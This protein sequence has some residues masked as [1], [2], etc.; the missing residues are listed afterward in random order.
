MN[1]HQNIKQSIRRSVEASVPDVLPA[2]LA[3][4]RLKE[5]NIM[6]EE[7]IIQHK[8]IIRWPKRLIPVAAALL[9][10]VGAWIG[11]LN[12]VVDSVVGFDVNPSLQLSVNRQEKVLKV[13][14]RNDEALTVLDD[15]DLKGVSLDVAVNA[16]I[17]SMV[18][19]GYLSE[20]RNSILVTVEHQN[21]EKGVQLQQRLSD[22]IAALLEGFSV[23]GSVMSQTATKDKERERSA[24]QYGISSGKTIL[25]RALIALDP[26]IQFSD[27]AH[28][29]I[30]DLNLLISAR[31]AAV[32]GLEVKGQASS[33]AYIGQEKARSIALMH[34]GVREAEITKIEIELDFEDGK[35]VYEVE[36]QAG[37]M[38]FDYDIDAKDGSV[39]AYESKRKNQQPDDPITAELIGVSRAEDIALTDAG[40]TKREITKLE[41]ELEHEKGRLIYDIEFVYA[42][43]QYEYDI[44]ALTGKILEIEKKKIR[45]NEQPTPTP[46]TTQV[47]KTVTTTMAKGD[48]GAKKAEDI[49][50]S[51]RVALVSRSTALKQSESVKKGA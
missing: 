33:G 15:M 10:L 17:G 42:G 39:I 40:V 2:L 28:L 50:L 26:A 31:A 20:I 25:I 11:W 46:P 38:A 30:N 41:V 14:A 29:S 32:P 45:S 24:K 13:D 23:H 12:L 22:E 47:S 19:Q 44:D 35:M 36:F 49:A 16:L 43:F 3:Q 27:V 8:K 4:I 9:L 5:D 18:R 51:T 21:S 6:E 34:A 7:Q 1:K 37:E 48:I